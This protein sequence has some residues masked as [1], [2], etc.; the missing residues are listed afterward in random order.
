M[1]SNYDVIVLGGGAGGVPA[2]IRAAQ[3]GARVALIESN[4]L[5]GLCM[6]RGCVPFSHM[7][8]ATRILKSLSLGKEMGLNFPDVSSDLRIFKKRQHEL[9]AFMRQGIKTTLTKNRV[10][11]VEGWGKIAGEGRLEVNSKTITFHKLIL[12]TGARWIKPDFPGSDLKEIINSDVLVTA[13]DLPKR[14]LLFGRDPRLAEIGQFLQRFGAQV[15]L[16]TPDRSILVGE[17][18]T[19]RSRLSKVL[20]DDGITIFR[21]AQILGVDKDGSDLRCRMKARDGEKVIRVDRVVT[22]DRAASLENLGLETIE[23]KENASYIDVNEKMETQVPGIYAVGDVAGESSRQYSHLA[24]AGGIAAA[25]NAMG[26]NSSFDHR[27]VCRIL[28]TQPQVACVGMT[29]KE[30][31]DVGYDVLT[32]TAPLSMNPLGMIVSQDEGMVEVV[33]EKEY[34]LVLGVHFIGESA[35]EMAGQGVLAIQMEALLEDLARAVFPHPALSESLAEA[36]RDAMG[37]SLYLP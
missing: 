32:G 14:A 2:A 30:A 33:A 25:E 4:F 37:I 28:N 10:D 7:M 23:L 31:K 34:G 19:I 35:V 9:I 11:I 24:A 12:A 36:A 5:G 16:A 26:A 22:L 13:E 18:K 6:N 20:K 3:L 21:E 8:A 1:E 27:T 29:S 17:Q 15:F